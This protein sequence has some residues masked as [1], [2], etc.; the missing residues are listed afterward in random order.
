MNDKRETQ[1][2]QKNSQNIVCT[3]LL[4]KKTKNEHE[5]VMPLLPK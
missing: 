3:R 5:I 4:E 2:T 1:N